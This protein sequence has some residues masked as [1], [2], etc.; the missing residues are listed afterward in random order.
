MEEAG[1]YLWTFLRLQ[2]EKI[3]QDDSERLIMI[4]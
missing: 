2:T 1:I 4:F 3:P